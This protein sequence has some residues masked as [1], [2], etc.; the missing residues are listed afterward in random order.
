MKNQGISQ[1]FKRRARARGMTL[2]DT[3]V[4]VSVVGSVSAVALPRLNGLPSEARV[5]VV[6][7]MAGAVRS[8]SHLVHMKCAVQATCGLHS[9]TGSVE[10]AG[11]TVALLH[12]YPLAGSP[13]GIANAI[14]YVGFTAQHAPEQTWF[15]KDGAPEPEACG[16]RYGGPTQPGQPPRVTVV[17]S[18]C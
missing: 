7:H 13:E 11:S 6:E 4:T 12:G 1:N 16:V 9:G 14:E 18:G 5:A 3:L 2:L 8:A 17:T 10:A 15:G